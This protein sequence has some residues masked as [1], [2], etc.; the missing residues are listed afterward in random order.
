MS[1]TL[2]VKAR[3]LYS[4]SNQ[5]SEVPDGGLS[6]ANNCV[7][8][9]DSVVESRRG[10]ERLSV[11]FSS[12][13][14]RADKLTAFQSQLLA[15]RSND[16]KLS[17]FNGS[18][19][20]D[21]SGT[22]PHV[23]SDYARIKFADMNGNK[24]FTTSSGVK[25]LDDY[26]GT[27]YSTGMPKGLDGEA[28]LSGSSGF[29]ANNT[30]I[31]YRIVWGSK[32]NNSN[33]YLGSASQRIVISNS[34]GATRDVVITF[35]IPS[36]ISTS[37]FYQIYR[38]GQSASS[39]T[40]PNDELQ[41]VY[42]GNPTSGEITA[43][44]ISVTDSTP[45]SLRGAF[46]YSNANQEGIS[47]SNDVPPLASDICPFKNFMFFS[48][49]K[50][51]HFL[52]IKL[53]AVSGSSGLAVNDTITIDSM[54][55]TA[56][57]AESIANKE[58]KVYTAGSASQ[59]ID[60]TARS[61]V[62]VINQYSS[63]T[64]VYA[65]YMTS[66]SDL[67][68]QI[69]IESRSLSASSFNV[70][71]SR[72][73]SWDIDDGV[74]DNSD[75]PHGLMW[76]KIQ[77]PE[78]VP[79]SHLEFVGSKNSP[80]R[81]IV[82][83]RDSLFILKEDGI[84]RL[85]GANGSW[86]IDPL[87]TS[88]HILAP[89]SAVV[90]NNQIFALTDQGI[91]TISDVGVAVISRPIED[92]ITELIGLNYDNLKK[93]SFGVSYETDRKYILWTISSSADVYP[94][95][96]FV[97]NTFTKT[98]TSWDKAANSALVSPV[99]DRLY[100]SQP[101]QKYVLKERKSFSFRDY[102]DE[103][104]DGISIVSYLDDVLVLNTV[105][106]LSVGDLFYENSTVYSPIIEIDS[107]S[108][109]VTLNDAKTWSLGSVS[110]FKGINCQ[111]EWASQTCGNPGIDKL[112]QEV[113]F[114]F[115]EQQFNTATV[116][117]YTDLVGGYSNSTITGSYGGGLWGA[118]I[119]GA[120]PWGGIQRPKPIRVF[121]P[122]DKTRGTMLSVKFTHRVGYGKFSLNGFSLQYDFVSERSN[123]A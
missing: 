15:H 42:E 52:N 90:L 117:F 12:D 94:T 1:Q 73:T 4:N 21:Y 112:F 27:V 44:S 106:G 122:R 54:V 18:A 91:V 102:I 92:K 99:D 75:Y 45:D 83:L 62:K 11:N 55:F 13:A 35:T 60:D 82:A 79:V 72:A 69:M 100:I 84:W 89:E 50:T 120:I 107:A 123:R 68:G 96:A 67:P 17:C 93:L 16:D 39:S 28:A 74:S 22:F 101:D 53:L 104:I 71:V 109:S 58:F 116:S 88:T 46:L 41:L 23:D 38:S 24:Y 56:K 36:G 3:G 76:S 70:S 111:L 121:V 95:Q 78:H 40:E 31:A 49:I 8:D 119:W 9:K 86:S 33:L 51:K 30:Q 81:R 98:W 87:D 80:I 103:N 10:F 2:M 57:S 20:T 48:G 110:V 114:L 25:V 6:K 47:E 14:D 63:N 85:T 7:I 32:D 5:L 113:M 29:M 43:K 26:L 108:N 59:N 65:Y 61:L 34:A 37:D 97:Y 105:D 115:R 66:Y 64:S 77:Q 19:W 118:F